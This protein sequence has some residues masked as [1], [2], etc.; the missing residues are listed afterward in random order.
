MFV[1]IAIICASICGLFYLASAGVFIQVC[2]FE[3]FCPGLIDRKSDKVG[4]YDDE[5]LAAQ[6]NSYVV[7]QM[8]MRPEFMDDMKEAAMNGKNVYGVNSMNVEDF[9]RKAGINTRPRVIKL[10]K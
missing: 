4:K 7:E 5:D 3:R 10:K 1:V 6:D 2:V 8:A 9:D